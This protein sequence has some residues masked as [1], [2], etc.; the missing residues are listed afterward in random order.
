MTLEQTKG[1]RAWVEV[2]VH[3]LRENARMVA[4]VVSPA[5]LIPMVK[6]NGYG[7]GAVEVARALEDMD[8]FAFGVATVEEGVEL[9]L[10]GVSARIIVFAACGVADTTA[11]IDHRLEGSAM[12]AAGLDL[13]AAADVP[14]HLEVETG[15]GR[16]G[17]GAREVAD[18]SREIEDLM[19]AGRLASIYSHFHSAR[20]NPAATDSQF[21]DFGRVLEGL[22]GDGTGAI[23][24]HIANS[25]AIR[26]KRQYHLDLVRPGL[27]LYGG[28]R[29]VDP[30]GVLP[31]P[32][33]VASIRARVL[34]VRVLPSGSTVS[35]GAT[36]VTKRA[37][38][39]ATLSIGYADG[40]PWAG[41][42]AGH[43]LIAGQPAPI[44]GRVCMDLICV[45][46]TGLSRV[47]PGDVATVLGS[48]GSEAIELSE[49]AARSGTIEYEVLTGL[50]RRLPR[51][52]TGTGS[53]SG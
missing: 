43:V 10:A 32:E 49:L 37:T 27:Y 1:Q 21:H 9:R 25:D 6:A 44:R 30:S 14:I 35:Y 28:G 22:P 53:G 52:Y 23:P 8:P 34:E 36:Y 41:S 19:A 5:G 20:T 24:R 48:D 13:L 17:L 3:A 33:A 16:A 29:E 26:S 40:L 7:L 45:D 42:N 12:G 47:K 38:R 11:M 18:R 51:V 50:G 2:N 15:M 4:R 46:V 39:L 31:R